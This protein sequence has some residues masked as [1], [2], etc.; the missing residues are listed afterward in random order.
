M[1]VYAYHV[2]EYWY[3]GSILAKSEIEKKRIED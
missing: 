2:R 3:M 1:Y